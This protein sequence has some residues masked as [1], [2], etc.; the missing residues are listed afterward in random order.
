MESKKH[1][2]STLASSALLVGDA[3]PPTDVGEATDN[4]TSAET[5]VKSTQTEPTIEPEATDS[6]K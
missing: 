2:L 5:S 4:S 1:W 6:S 3:V